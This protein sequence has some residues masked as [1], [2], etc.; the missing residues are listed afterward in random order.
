MSKSFCPLPWIHHAVR[1]NGDVRVCCMANVTANQGVLR[2]ENGVPFNALHDSIKDSRNAEILKTMRLNMLNGEWS[3]ECGRCKIEEETGLMARRPNEVDQWKEIFTF[4]DAKKLTND[5]GSTDVMPIHF[6]L[7][8]GNFCNL[9]CRMCG[10][11]E[12][13]SWYEEHTGMHNEEGFYDTQG[14]VKLVRND[15]GRWVTDEYGWHQHEFFWDHLDSNIHE[16]QQVYMAGGEPL[17]IERHYEFLQRCID[18]DV[19]KNILLEYN[20]NLSVL[21]DRVLNMWAQFKRVR[22]G[23]STDGMEEVLEYQRYPLKWDVMYTNL[24]KLDEFAKKHDHIYPALGYTVSA[25][26]AFHLPKF[27][28]WKLF[29]S[30]FEK[31][32]GIERRPVIGYHMVHEPHRVCTQMFPVE[33]K[34]ELKN[35]YDV[36][37]KKL[38]ESTL[39]SNVKETAINILNSVINFTFLEDRS[40]CISDFVK[41]TKYLDKTRN[42]DIKMIVPELGNLFD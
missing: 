19:A 20:T 14:F 36:W 31:V 3:P 23:A 29:H 32:N 11:T 6:D 39:E 33:I 26:N 40:D 22:I 1:T 5:D 10:P 21:P 4:E 24:K 30:G 37:I 27:I 17:L 28:W 18:L 9:K 7:R 16:L 38:E 13:H 12:S 15:K 25:Y 35:Q 8:F 2:K 42:Q 34:N 41:F